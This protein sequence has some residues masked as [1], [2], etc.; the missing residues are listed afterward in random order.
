M[1]TYKYN[2]IYANIN[3]K[4]NRLINLEVFYLKYNSF[5]PEYL[6]SIVYDNIFKIFPISYNTLIILL[7]P[8]IYKKN[9]D[10]LKKSQWW[11]KE[12]IQKYQDQKLSELLKHASK[13]VPYYHSLFRKLNVDY[14]EFSSVDDLAKLP[15]LS[16]EEVRR[17]GDR[18]KATNFPKYKFMCV[19]TGGTAGTPL[20]VFVNKGVWDVV[21][22]TFFKAYLDRFLLNSNDKYVIL[23]RTQ[24]K[25]NTPRKYYEYGLF[26]KILVLFPSFMNNTNIKN[27]VKKI[28]NYKPFC[29]ITYPSIITKLAIYMRRNKIP[30]FKNLKLISCSVENLHDWQRNKLEEFFNCRVS[31]IYGHAESATLAATCEK[32]NYF[33]FFPEY[34]ITEIVGKD[35]NLITTEGSKGEIIA[36][37]FINNIFPLIRYRT[38]DIGVYTEKKCRCG[39]NY[40]IIKSIQ[41]RKQEYLISKDGSIL[42]VISTGLYYFFSENLKNFMV[43][44]IIQE[45]EG[46]L[47]LNIVKDENF[48]EINVSKVVKKFG[49]RFGTDF[50]LNIC[51]KDNIK[52]GRRG[53]R[54]YFIQKLQIP[55]EKILD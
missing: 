49:K 17:N 11:T 12:K 40:Q 10:K 22:L 47:V 38:G 41:G 8:K 9:I 24:S 27:Y 54:I 15:L 33:H 39:R 43:S 52:Q 46:E 26:S 32:S 13:N 35:N 29:I 5:I 19:K 4:I 14:N 37:G 3:Q 45:N 23:R 25:Y 18:F 6:K 30:P 51:Y 20:N 7:Y 31:S 53:E 34:G 21:H 48:D 44:Q 36:T 1:R 2:N 55:I 50:N 16:K 42:P 28:Q